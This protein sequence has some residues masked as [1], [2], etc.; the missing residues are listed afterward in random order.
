MTAR[1]V[2]RPVRRQFGAAAA[3]FAA[4][5]LSGVLHE[6]AISMPVR[7]GYGGPLAYFLLH[8]GLVLLERRL[9]AAGCGPGAWGVMG[10]V[11]TAVWLLGPLPWLFHASFLEGVVWPL[12]G[13]G[14]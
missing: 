5:A 13:V 2:Y 4:F 6:V 11:W 9:S 7:A 3:L 1:I 10:R 8:G 12:V 14:P